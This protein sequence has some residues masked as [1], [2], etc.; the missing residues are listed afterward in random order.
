MIIHISFTSRGDVRFNLF[1]SPNKHSKYHLRQGL[2]N[3]VLEG[4]SPVEFLSYQIENVFTFLGV[5]I[6]SL[7]GQKSRFGY[8][9]AGLDLDT[10]DFLGFYNGGRFALPSGSHTGYQKHCDVSFHRPL[11]CRQPQQSQKPLQQKH[12][13]EN[14]GRGETVMVFASRVSKCISFVLQCLFCKYRKRNQLE[15]R[16]LCLKKHRTWNP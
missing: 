8:N 16:N 14:E 12:W 2:P 1:I 5:P 9:P 6:F 10:P 3:P 11:H 7:V 13:G 4:P 15:R